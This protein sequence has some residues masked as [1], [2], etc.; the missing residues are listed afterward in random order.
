MVTLFSS[1]TPSN[2]RPGQASHRGAARKRRGKSD[3]KVS[4]CYARRLH[5]GHRAGRYRLPSVGQ[6]VHLPRWFT[7]VFLPSVTTS[8]PSANTV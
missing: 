8:R 3:G 5:E 2:A 6:Y 1:L 7:S 4:V